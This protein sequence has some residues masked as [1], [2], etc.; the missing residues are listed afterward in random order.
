MKQI[1]M[2]IKMKR[3]KHKVFKPT[4]ED[5]VLTAYNKKN[6]KNNDDGSK[7]TSAQKIQIKLMKIQQLIYIKNLKIKQVL[8]QEL[9]GDINLDE[10]NLEDAIMFHCYD[11]EMLFKR[12]FKQDNPNYK[13]DG[14]IKGVGFDGNDKI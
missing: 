11:D 1:Q 5:K 6:S 10:V 7:G 8:I 4:L 14:S 12:L 2:V 9:D 13:S 3:N